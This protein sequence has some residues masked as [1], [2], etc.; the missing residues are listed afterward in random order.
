MTGATSISFSRIV[1]F[2]AFEANLDSG[3]LRKHD[4]RVHLRGQSFQVLAA[5]LEHPGEIVTRGELHHRLWRGEVFVD[6]E[7]DLNAV[8]ARLRQVLSDRADK[9]RFIETMPRF[10]YRFVAPVSYVPPPRQADRSRI[11]VLPFLNLSGNPEKEYLVD[12]ITDEIITGLASIDSEHLAVIALT[13]AMRYKHARRDVTA[14]RRELN[15]QYIAEGSVRW[16]GDRIRV[17]VRLIQTNDQT[18]LVARR[19][20]AIPSEIFRLHASIVKRIASCMPSLSPKVRRKQFQRKPTEDMGAY[21]EY[22]KGRHQLWK[23]TAESLTEARQHLESALARDPCFAAACNALAELY[24]SVEFWGYVPP[25]ETDR[26]GRYYALRAM[27]IDSSSAET[28]VFL[29]L[30]SPRIGNKLHDYDWAGIQDQIAHARVLNPGLRMV[31]VRHAMVL[32][33]LGNPDAAATELE[34][35]LESD[36]LSFDVRAWLTMMFYLGRHFDRA[37][38][39]A[40]RLEDLEPGHFASYQLL[41]YVYLGMH[42]FGEAVAAFRKSVELSCELPISLGL[43]GMSLGF[44]GN[45]REAQV[46]LE[47]LRN[48][49]SQRYVKPTCYAF[50]HLG[51]GN[52]DEAFLWLDRS[53]DARDRHI[54]PIK[55]YPFLDPLRS[56][57]RFTALLRKM[58]LA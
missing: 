5:L 25:Q 34:F 47:R 15:V 42:R 46:V 35:A 16:I 44:E 28:H 20:E 6:F 51:L 58:N 45:R 4:L 39:E 1:R 48:L 29:S 36:P 10:G 49:A 22:I 31:R 38:K 13:T 41:G 19:F 55:T 40:T 2:E 3:E 11:I 14:I 26:M 17:N 24:W 57:A 21:D 12:A 54:E 27:E 7:N 43:L 53:I 8:V 18:Q 32:A 33:I 37:L 56:D 50:T 30:F 23:Y 52:I 9:P